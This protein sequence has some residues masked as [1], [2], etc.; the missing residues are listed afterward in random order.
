[1][2]DKLTVNEPTYNLKLSQTEFEL[3]FSLLGHVRLSIDGNKYQQAA[4]DLLISAEE[5]WLLDYDHVNIEFK[6]WDD[7]DD[8]HYIEVSGTPE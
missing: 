1:M 5:Q 2:T 8:G 7:E 3:V 4:Y 6:K